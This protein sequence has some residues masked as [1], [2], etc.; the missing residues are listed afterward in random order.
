MSNTIVLVIQSLVDRLASVNSAEEDP[1]ENP[2]F[3][4]KTFSAHWNVMSK[5]IAQTAG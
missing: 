2:R 3:K 1:A 5:Q 4:T